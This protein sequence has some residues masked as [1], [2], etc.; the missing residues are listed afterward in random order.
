MAQNICIDYHHKQQKVSILSLHSKSETGDELTMMEQV[1]DE[2]M[3]PEKEIEI[4]KFYEVIQ[5]TFYSFPEKQPP[6]LLLLLFAIKL[7]LT[8]N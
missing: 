5:H 7:V 4:S 1:E 8:L 3:K 6:A 2:V